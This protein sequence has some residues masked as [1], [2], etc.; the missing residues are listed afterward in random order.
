MK[1]R[2]FSRKFKLDATDL[3]I[4]KGFSYREAQNAIGVSS[5]V[6]RTWVIQVQKELQVVM[7]ADAKA[8][9]DEQILA[10]KADGK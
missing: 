8:I 9:T 2:T 4:E 7:P 3:I 6:I 1:R 5:G 10:Q